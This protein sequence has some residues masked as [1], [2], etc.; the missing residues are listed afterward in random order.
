V[1]CRSATFICFGAALTCGGW[2]FA[3]APSKSAP[4]SEAKKAD[5]R[6]VTELEQFL[7]ERGYTAVPLKPSAGYVVVEATI[8]DTK[9]RL[10]CDTGAPWSRL[11][12][13]RTKDLDIDWHESDISAPAGQSDYSKWCRI[14]IMDLS[15]FKAL[16]TKCY[17]HDATTY[18]KALEAFNEPPLDGELGA[19]VML[20]YSAIID[21]RALRLYLRAWKP[22][23]GGEPKTKQPPERKPADELDQFVKERGY[24]SVP[25]ERCR[26]GNFVVAANIGAK[27]LRLLCDTGAPSSTLDEKRTKDLKIPWENNKVA[28]A[29]GLGKTGTLEVMELN[30]FKAHGIRVDSYDI[31]GGNKWLEQYGDAPV[32]GLLGW[33][34]M[35]ANSG[36]I[37]IRAARLYL[38][39]DH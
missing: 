36:I 25:L 38:R 8:G 2:L 22:R 24:S 5:I 31:E 17:N 4:D 27:K 3:Q 32:D 11:D 1:R 9:L 19:D 14:E 34:V 13:K 39:S 21:S 16:A 29:S 26:N 37:D 33:G 10:M 23:M 7:K 12:E 15:G 28:G 6:R 20:D 35:K 30:G 18:N